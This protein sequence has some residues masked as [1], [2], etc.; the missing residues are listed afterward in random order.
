MIEA[1]D[2]TVKGLFQNLKKRKENRSEQKAWEVNNPIKMEILR[3]LDELKRSP[4]G[5]EHAVKYKKL[6]HLMRMEQDE[7]FDLVFSGKVTDEND[8]WQ[9]IFHAGHGGSVKRELNGHWLPFLRRIYPR[10]NE[11]PK[12]ISQH[13]N[14]LWRVHKYGEDGDSGENRG[15]SK[16]N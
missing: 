14:W 9:L 15:S 2:G 10:R 1:N 4:S 5:S 16:V 12:F 11:L 13:F 8:L 6:Q 7:L 3:L